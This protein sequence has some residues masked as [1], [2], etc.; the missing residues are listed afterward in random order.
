MSTFNDTQSELKKQFLGFLIAADFQT[1][2]LIYE[3]DLSKGFFKLHF[4][5]T[6]I[7]SMVPE[8]EIRPIYNAV[9]E[10][11][12]HFEKCSQ[13]SLIDAYAGLSKIMADNFYSDLHIGMIPTST[14]P[15]TD[16]KPENK[17]ISPNQTSRI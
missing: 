10:W 3:G 15:G 2:E 16:Q 17:P 14:L 4:L 8:S 1:G 6:K 7:F 11:M 9:E 5:I 12:Q 13:K